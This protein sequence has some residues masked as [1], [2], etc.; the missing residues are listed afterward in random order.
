MYTVFHLLVVEVLCVMILVYACWLDQ[1][2]NTRNFHHK[3][4]KYGVAGIGFG[5]LCLCSIE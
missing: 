4:M 5:I 3:R 2:Q 1:K